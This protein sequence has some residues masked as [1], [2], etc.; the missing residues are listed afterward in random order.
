MKRKKILVVFLVVFTILLSS[1]G[2]YFYQMYNTPNILVDK[3]EQVFYIPTGSDFKFVQQGL[4]ETAIVQDLVSFSFMAKMMDYDQGVKPG[5][6]VFKP[7]MTNKEAIRML[8]MGWQSPTRITFHNIRTAS[9]LAGQV[10][11]NIELD[12]ASLATLL[13]DST[14]ASSYGFSAQEFYTMFLPDTYEVYWNISAGALLDRMHAEYKKFWNEERKWLA[15]SL[16]LSPEEVVTLA[17]IVQA[18]TKYN[19]ESPRVAGV[20]LNRL[21]KGIALQA[22]PTL[23]FA[24]GDYSIKRVLNEHKKI[25]SP[26]N[27]YKYRGLPPGPINLPSKT[28]IDAVL[29]AESHKYYYFCAR[30][31]FSGY[32]A[33]AKNLRE[34]NRNAAQY[35][36]ALNKARI[37]R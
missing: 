15:D 21:K 1:F 11:E 6:Y 34:H 16:D 8:L 7:D 18:E 22:D 13:I 3:P 9:E 36:R 27:T 4:H 29:H 30:A 10:T 2:L 24:L 37:Y 35:Q 33:F 28:N 14:T 23:I 17:S 19:D 26:Y 32:H 20:Y 25:D 5:R 31:D 12:S